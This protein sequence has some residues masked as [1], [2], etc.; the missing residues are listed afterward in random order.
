MVFVILYIKSKK[1]RVC[2]LSVTS[3]IKAR[4]CSRGAVYGK[5]ERFDGVLADTSS[6]ALL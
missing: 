1:K 4:V 5:R 2:L 6:Q 3:V